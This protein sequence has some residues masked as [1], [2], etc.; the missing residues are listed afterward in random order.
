MFEYTKLILFTSCLLIGQLRAQTDCGTCGNACCTMEFQVDQKSEDLTNLMKDNLMKGGQDGNYRFIK[1]LNLTNQERPSGVRY[2]IQAGHLGKSSNASLQFLI[3]SNYSLT[4]T[5]R[6]FSISTLAKD[7]CDS[8]KNYMLMM[9]FVK[10]LAVDFKYK[11][12]FGCSKT[13]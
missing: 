4:S 2:I 13:F 3:A 8:G 12:L 7:L 11:S 9:D 1:F 6:G 10:N 5:V